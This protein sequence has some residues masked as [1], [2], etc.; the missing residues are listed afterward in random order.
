MPKKEL[1]NTRTPKKSSKTN[2][3]PEKASDGKPV[4]KSAVIDTE[5]SES[6]SAAQKKSNSKPAKSEPSFDSDF[7]DAQEKKKPE[8]GEEA[9]EPEEEIVVELP[10]EVQAILEPQAD[11]ADKPSSREEDYALIDQIIGGDDRAKHLAYKKL[12]SKYKNQIYSLVLKIVHNQNEVEDLVQESFS[13]AFNSIANFNKEFA[14]STWLYRIATNSSIDYLRKRRLKT[15][16][17]DSPIQTKDDEFYV[18]IPDSREE[19]SKNVVQG[20]RDQLVREA[21]ALLPDKYKVV[22][23]MRHLQERTYEEI[24][25]DLKLP[26]GTV[27]A[28]IFRAREMLYRMLRDKLRNY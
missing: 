2:P 11:K 20:Q 19:P 10:K 16:S 15:Y 23:E 5:S 17:I 8:N 26:L 13:K 14:F 28:H 22:I 9:E 24:A 21:I 3:E 4:K 12:L 25:E 18:E 1:S 27:K 6:A 7:D